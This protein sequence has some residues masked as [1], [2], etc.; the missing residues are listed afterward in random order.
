MIE[1]IDGFVYRFTAWLK[2]A[3]YVK[4]VL[5]R[6]IVVLILLGAMGFL[7]FITIPVSLV[8]IYIKFANK[9]IKGCSCNHCNVLNDCDDK[10]CIN[11][12]TS[13]SSRNKNNDECKCEKCNKVNDCNDKF[14]IQCGNPM[15]SKNKKLKLDIVNSID[16]ILVALFAKVA[17]A[18]GKISKEEAKYI[19]HV[20]DELSK[21]RSPIENDKIKDIYK[22]ILNIEKTNLQNIDV[23]CKKLSLISVGTDFKVNIVTMFVELAYIDSVYDISEENIIVKI[24]HNLNLDF[25]MYQDIKNK[26]E[27]KQNNN[28]FNGGNISIEECY[29]ILQSKQNDS[30]DTI[31]SNY[32]KL[33]KQYHYDSMASKELPKDMI[34]FAEEKLK[35]INAAYENIRNK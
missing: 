32:R 31:K 11:C 17:K 14:C 18:D 15:E 10:F 4:D 20:F 16:G 29:E 25:K 34:E 26:F 8:Y 12:G 7:F 2:G 13:L 28:N 33:V 27:P 19:G 1:I 24:V 22:E 5:L 3:E 30:F 6:I 23:L 9:R 35:L 21:S